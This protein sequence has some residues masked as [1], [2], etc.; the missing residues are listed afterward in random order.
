MERTGGR[1]EG[2]MEPRVIPDL[3]RH[4]RE[5]HRKADAFLVKR[6]G[7][8]TPVS[9]DAFDAEV[10]AAAAALAARGVKRGDRVALLSENR[11]EWAIVDLAI[12]SLGAA[13]VPIYPTLPASQVR[14]LLADSGAVGA[15]ASNEQQRA[16]LEESRAGAPALQW[17]QCFDPDGT[18]ARG[19]GAAAS[20]TSGPAPSPPE[21]STPE[22]DDLATIIYTSGTTGMPKGV[23]LTH[24]NLVSNTLASLTALAL[25]PQD[26]HLS[27]LPLNHIFERTAGYYVMLYAGA[28]IAY[29][30]SIEKAA[31]NLQEIRPTVLLGVPRFYEKIVERAM[32]VAAAAG[33]PRDVMARWG[34]D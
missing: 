11:I 14:P 5:V 3:L 23:M 25:G 10:R 12:L 30:E 32:E 6:D 21:P 19:G 15:F 16:K 17:I 28:T 18:A 20:A 33:F 7:R 4:A 1:M 8:W 24:R 22:P 2:R 26:T 34:R 13:T 9:I 29:A 31:A 27:F